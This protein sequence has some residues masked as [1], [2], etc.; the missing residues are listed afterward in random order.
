M[1]QLE[2]P[3]GYRLIYVELLSENIASSLSCKFCSGSVLLHEV[4]RKGLASS[5]V[6]HCENKHCHSQTEFYSSQLPVGNS[7]VNTVNRRIA[8][9]MCC[10]GG[11]W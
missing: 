3:K 6:F 8:F 2:S 4:G 9:T 7:S 5:F 10:V 1:L 11:V